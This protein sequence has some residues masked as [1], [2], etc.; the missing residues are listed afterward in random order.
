MQLWCG[1]DLRL[2]SNFPRLR[3]VYWSA[4]VL[5]HSNSIAITIRETETQ[6]G[7]CLLQASATASWLLSW[8]LIPPYLPTHD[9]EGTPPFFLA[10]LRLQLQ[11][12]VRHS[13]LLHTSAHQNLFSPWSCGRA[14]RFVFGGRKLWFRTET[15]SRR[16]RVARRQIL[17]LR[18]TAFHGGSC[19]GRI[20]IHP[21]SS[22]RCFRFFFWLCGTHACLAR[23]HSDIRSRG[24]VHFGSLVGFPHKPFSNFLFPLHEGGFQI[25][26]W[27]IVHSVSRSLSFFNSSWR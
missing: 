1:L 25:K 17:L 10:L 14:L 16:W 9:D 12:Q 20:A 11:L 18:E 23:S 19:S 5:S 24:C 26:C 3:R 8:K 15:S 2:T 27:R 22:F 6:R 4:H 21:N 13:H 7:G